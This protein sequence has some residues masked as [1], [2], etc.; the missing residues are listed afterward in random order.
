MHY[1]AKRET[2]RWSNFISAKWGE[3]CLIWA[4]LWVWGSFLVP[5][6]LFFFNR[7]RSILNKYN[8]LHSERMIACSACR[9]WKLPVNLGLQKFDSST[10]PHEKKVPW[11]LV[12]SSLYVITRAACVCTALHASWRPKGT[13][14]FVVHSPLSRTAA[15]I[16]DP[17]SLP[18]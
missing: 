1:L 8:K 2:F 16:D 13:L 15:V 11:K 9:V 10:T 7:N 5:Y 17:I 4:I 12:L 3:N 14:G 6:Y 18:L